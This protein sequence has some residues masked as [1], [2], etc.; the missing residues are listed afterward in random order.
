MYAHRIFM[1]PKA[2]QTRHPYYIAIASPVQTEKASKNTFATRTSSQKEDN[3]NWKIKSKALAD[4]VGEEV[5][6]LGGLVGSNKK[7]R[8][9]LT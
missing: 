2:W 3:W 7:E 9:G 1:V 5:D 8:I 6:L 4:A